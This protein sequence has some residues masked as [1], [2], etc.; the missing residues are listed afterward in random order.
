MR[1]EGRDLVDLRHGDPEFFRQRVQMTLGQAP[2]LVLDEM[3]V[4]D[5]QGALAGAVAEQGFDSC[6]LAVF[7]N[8]TTGKRRSFTAA[9]AWVDCPAFSSPHATHFCRR[10][11]HARAL[12][13]MTTVMEGLSSGAPKNKAIAIFWHTLYHSCRDCRDRWTRLE[14]GVGHDDTET[15]RSRSREDI[16]TRRDQMVALPRQSQL[17][18]LFV[19]LRR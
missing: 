9:G 19:Q 8:A 15:I 14:M 11:I 12:D 13:G 17:S 16:Y 6:D 3:Q 18:H 5:Q 4:F 10:F 1:I 2:F 7:E